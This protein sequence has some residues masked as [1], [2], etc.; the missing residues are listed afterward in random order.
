MGELGNCV[1]WANDSEVE[2][3]MKLVKLAKMEK[4][5]K[6]GKPG[7]WVELAKVVNVGQVRRN[8]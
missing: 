5:R 6:C 2:K 4:L 8:G 3:V 1:I 7:D